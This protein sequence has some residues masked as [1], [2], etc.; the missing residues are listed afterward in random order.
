MDGCRWICIIGSTELV[1]IDHL[2]AL[3]VPDFHPQCV[4]ATAAAGVTIDC[5]HHEC[6]ISRI[7]D[8][9]GTFVL[10]FGPGNDQPIVTR[11][12]EAQPRR[13]E[14]ELRLARR[15]TRANLIFGHEPKSSLAA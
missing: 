12:A 15:H 5:G 14:V 10:G 1:V 9:P 2:V 13:F 8:C 11:A 6:E 3:L 7:I 4:H